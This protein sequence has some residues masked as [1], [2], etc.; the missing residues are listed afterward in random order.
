M[1]I[2]CISVLVFTIIIV[3]IVISVYKWNSKRTRDNVDTRGLF[4]NGRQGDVLPD[5]GPHCERH[6]TNPLYQ[7]DPK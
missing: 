1:I 3:T 6:I 4:S 2:F 5:F 7:T